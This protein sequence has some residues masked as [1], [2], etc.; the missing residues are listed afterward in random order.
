MAD[1]EW[2]D[3]DEDREHIKE[4]LRINS[5][6]TSDDDLLDDFGV[7]ANR[8]I[9]NILFPFKDKIPATDVTEDLKEAASHYIMRRYK[10]YQKALDVAAEYKKQFDE[11]MEAVLC[12][13]KA[14]P[15]GRTDTVIYSNRYR[16]EPLRTRQR[17]FGD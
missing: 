2:Y 1:S 3:K 11:I 9:D 13:L 10:V 7:K 6:D 14:V 8:Q 4:E 17:Y 16:S 12:R 5:T 15:E